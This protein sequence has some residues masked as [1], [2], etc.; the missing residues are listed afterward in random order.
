M[1]G[2]GTRSASHFNKTTFC[3]GMNDSSESIKFGLPGDEEFQ[4]LDALKPDLDVFFKSAGM[5][6]KD[7][8][9]EV[10]FKCVVVTVPNG[11]SKALLQ[12]L[13]EFILERIPAGYG[14]HTCVENDE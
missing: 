9:V 2:T 3:P 4:V 12:S 6:E 5:S 7:W 11:Y 13:N 1:Q 10:R 14:L 8:I